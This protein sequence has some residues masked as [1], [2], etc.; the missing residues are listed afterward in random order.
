METATDGR[1]RAEIEAIR[2]VDSHEHIVSEAWRTRQP[3]DL[4]SMLEYTN[5]DLVS[6]GMPAR[7]MAGL[8]DPARSL[9]ERWRDFAPCWRHV[10]T[11]GYGRAVLVAARELFG[12]ADIGD[13]TYRELSERM[14][15]ANHPGWYEEVLRRRAGIEIAVNQ[16]IPEFDPTPLE[17][18]DRG[19]FA[20]VVSLDEFISPVL[21]SQLDGLGERHGLAIR[22]LDDL[23]EALDRALERARA[24]GVVAIKIVLAYRRSLLFER[25]STADAERI[26]NR[27]PRYPIGWQ[28]DQPELAPVSWAEAKPLQDFLVHRLVRRCA[29]T[30]LP[31]QVHTGLQDGNGNALANANPL[32]LTNLFVEYPEARFDVFHAGYPWIGEVAALAKMFP[33]V[34]ADL[35]WVHVISPWVARRTLHEWIETVPANKILGFGGDSLAVEGAYAHAR[36]ARANVR[37]VLAE[38]V[39]AGY[40]DEDEAITLARRILR[41]NAIELFGLSVPAADAPEAQ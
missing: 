5:S 14:A 7:V 17:E 21:R 38:K 11:T 8:R 36:L 18:I 40:L 39:A 19:L 20:P 32:L 27:L 41:E 33:N 2:L 34:Y 28:P 31:I 23:V 3:V 37:Q 6:A 9:D 1:L 10:R 13:G 35:C 30:R 16:P 22:S 24:A 29:A 25:C 15:A 12:V 26:F 4:F